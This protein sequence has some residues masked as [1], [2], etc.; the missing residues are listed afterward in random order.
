MPHNGE[1]P[2]SLLALVLELSIQTH[3]APAASP[4]GLF[5]R[6][7]DGGLRAGQISGTFTSRR[8]TTSCQIP[9]CKVPGQM[10]QRTFSGKL[11]KRYGVSLV[12]RV[13]EV[14]T[15]VPVLLESKNAYLI[16]FLCFG[17]VKL[18][19]LFIGKHI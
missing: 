18:R 10:C 6:N 4:P 14:A 5:S 19:T 12:V 15:I 11:V 16:V 17:S 2:A 3:A 13:K 1:C 7:L 8:R 9:T